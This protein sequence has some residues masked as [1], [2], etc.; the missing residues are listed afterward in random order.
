MRIG[1]RW[2]GAARPHAWVD[3]AEQSGAFALWADLSAE[4]AVPASTVAALT[5]DPRIVARVTLGAENPV[6]LAEEIAVL[7]LVSGGRVVCVVDTGELDADGAAEDLWLLRASWAARPLS[8]QGARWTVPS[9]LNPG[10]PTSVMVTP[11]PSQVDVPVWLTGA[12]APQLSSATGLPMLAEDPGACDGAAQVQP[13]TAAL[14]GDLDTDRALVVGWAQAGATHL[15]ATVPD[16]AT[17]DFL[18]RY[19]ARYLQPEVAMPAFPRIMAEA[20][21]PASL[22]EK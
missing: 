19:V 17:E 7:D 5:T 15:L 11:K 9:G 13:A 4:G 21:L 14:T 22:D 6:T 20:P 16:D 2:T 3:A 10:A 12:V 8:H 18:V 1:I